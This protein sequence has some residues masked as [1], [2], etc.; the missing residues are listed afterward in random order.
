ML[1]Y[2]IYPLTSRRYSSFY[3]HGLRSRSVYTPTWNLN[4]HILCE[5]ETW[6]SDSPCQEETINDVITLVVSLT[7]NLQTRNHS[8]SYVIKWWLSNQLNLPRLFTVQIWTSYHIRKLKNEKCLIFSMRNLV[9]K[10]KVALTN[11]SLS[12]HRYFRPLIWG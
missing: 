3:I 12:T 1:D 11:C 7:S 4:F 5:V 10:L 6:T 9:G 8:Q 2:I